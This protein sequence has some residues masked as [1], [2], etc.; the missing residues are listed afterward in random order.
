MDMINL[1]WATPL[2]RVQTNTKS[3]AEELRQFIL[4]HEKEEFRKPNPPQRVHHGLFESNFDFLKWPDPVIA[5]FKNAFLTHL[6]NFVQ[7]VNNL[8][9]QEANELK[10]NYH[11]WFHTYRNGAYFQSHNHSMASWSAIYC[12]DPGDEVPSDESHSGHVVFSDPRDV[13][14]YLDPANKKMRRDL[15]FDLVRVRPEQAELVIF[16]SYLKHW[17]EPYYGERPRITIAANFWFI[18]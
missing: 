18:F 15:S 8:S 4:A 12:V 1:L 2:F 10:F 13:N 7:D 5:K 9:D 14:M 6:G 17:V 11:C 3:L 16:P